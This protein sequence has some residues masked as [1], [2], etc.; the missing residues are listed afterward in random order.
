[1]IHIISRNEK[2]DKNDIESVLDVMVYH[3]CYLDLVKKIETGCQD[4]Q[5]APSFQALPTMSSRPRRS[6]TLPAKKPNLSC[7]LG[8]AY[9]STDSEIYEMFKTV[10][11][12]FKED[13]EAMTEFWLTNTSEY[14]LANRE[15]QQLLSR[16][17]AQLDLKH[18]LCK[19]FLGSLSRDRVRS[20]G[21]VRHVRTKEV[22][23]DIMITIH[24]RVRVGQDAGSRSPH[25]YDDYYKPHNYDSEF[26]AT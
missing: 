20:L 2:I 19:R 3:L 8:M 7:I 14:D 21:V 10:C 11:K 6:C 22:G 4:V 1:M 13:V 16:V 12:Y 5:S 15:H 23:E 24:Y 17:F 25:D 9:E 26:F 18:P